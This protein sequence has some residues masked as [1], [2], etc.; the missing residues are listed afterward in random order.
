MGF[1]NDVA[2]RFSGANR[3]KKWDLFL[4]AIN[5]QPDQIILDVGFSEM[6]YSETDNF[7]EKH[8]PYPSQ[9]T[10]LGIDVPEMFA[11]RYPQ[12]KAV[13]YDGRDFPFDDKSFDLV[14][15]NAVIEHVG[16]R[17]AQLHFLKEICRVG[18]KIWL[19]TPNRRFPFEIHTRIPLLHLLGKGIFD[20]ILRLFGMDWATGPRLVLL[21]KKEMFSLL[22]E[23]GVP[24][25]KVDVTTNRMFGF[26]LD[27]VFIID[28]T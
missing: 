28:L 14:W 2:Y 1:I 9:I 16:Y 18:K 15:S 27:Y 5:P 25:D 11:K 4:K 3:R 17:E 21:T 20:P 7:L 13:H 10:A 26:E 24:R 22:D 23:A 12:V 19:T 6:E 8:Y